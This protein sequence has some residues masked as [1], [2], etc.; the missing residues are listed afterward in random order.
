MMS[1]RKLFNENKDCERYRFRTKVLVVLDRIEQ[2][3]NRDENSVVINRRKN[4]HRG[5]VMEPE[6]DDMDCF[7]KLGMSVSHQPLD[8]EILISW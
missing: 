3:I 8:E 6:L 7:R 4:I 1:I 2:A 5:G